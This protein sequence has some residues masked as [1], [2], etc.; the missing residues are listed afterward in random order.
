MKDLAV[1]NRAKDTSRRQGDVVDGQDAGAGVTGIGDSPHGFMARSSM[2]SPG[3][4]T[5]SPAPTSAAAQNASL[6]VCRGRGVPDGG[7][8]D[9]GMGGAFLTSSAEFYRGRSAS[10][11]PGST[12]PQTQDE[13]L[14]IRA[15]P[16]GAGGSGWLHAHC[17][18]LVLGQLV[19]SS[20]HPEV[21]SFTAASGKWNAKN[22]WPGNTSSVKCQLGYGRAGCSRRPQCRPEHPA[23]R[24]QPDAGP[25]AR[26]AAAPL[27]VRRVIVPAL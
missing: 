12:G 6:V 13:R 24:R 3:S 19:T 7:C 22:T 18:H 5:M 1:G 23:E 14:S 16:T 15:P 8:S 27:A 10:T 26:W 9:P 25:G 17:S 21:S 20:V 11:W 2:H 4:S